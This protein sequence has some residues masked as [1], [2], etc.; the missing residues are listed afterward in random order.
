MPRSFSELE[1][2][3]AINQMRSAG[4]AGALALFMAGAAHAGVIFDSAN[5]HSNALASS[6]AGT[7]GNGSGSGSN[8]DVVTAFTPTL[9]ASSYGNGTTAGP[10]FLIEAQGQAFENASA[11]FASASSGTINFSGMVSN[12]VFTADGEAQGQDDGEYYNYAFDVTSPANF[13]LAYDFTE[14][15]VGVNNSYILID[16]TAG[17]VV[18]QLNSHGNVSGDTAVSL[19]A[20]NYIFGA[21]TEVGDFAYQSG[22]GS[23]SGSHNEDFNFNITSAAPEPSTWLLMFAG[24]GGIGLMLRRAKKTMGFRF[25]DALSG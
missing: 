15:Y 3:V 7:S 18:S 17:T 24:I 20:G 19:A 13:K 5:V 4:A 25:K 12:S 6:T 16:Q 11:S 10:G 2:S 14:S 22:I 21:S 1:T 8:A 9:N 23:S